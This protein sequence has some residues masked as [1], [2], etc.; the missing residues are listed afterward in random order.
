MK[1]SQIVVLVALLLTTHALNVKLSGVNYNPR[2]GADWEPWDRKCKST[3]EVELDLRAI[4]LITDNIRLYSMND[5]NQVELVIPVA[6]EV[7]LKVWLGMWIDS[8]NTS[9]PAELATLKRLIN[10]GVIDN[11]VTGLHVGSEA[12]YRQDVTIAKAIEYFYE[13]KGTTTAANLTFPITIADVGDVYAGHPELFQVVDVVSANSF[14]FWENKTIE[15]CITYFYMRM[16]PIMGMAR[17]N[18]KKIIIS[19]TGWATAGWAYKAGIATPENAA[20]WMNDFHIF[21]MEFGWTYY[22][23]I[24]FDTLWRYNVNSNISEPEVENYFGLFDE[25]RMLKPAYANLNIHKRKEYY[26]PPLPTQPDVPTPTKSNWDVFQN[27]AAAIISALD[28]SW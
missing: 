22:Y 6:K 18:N 27:I 15:E 12:I 23:Y 8:Y 2:K 11:D 17:V 9:Y 25:N 26:V 28:G 19:E 24:A 20:L 13:V 1:E 5:C 16:G 21:A 7:G 10:N 4:S 3:E 14:P